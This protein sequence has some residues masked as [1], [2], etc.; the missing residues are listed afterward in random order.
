MVMRNG[1]VE[2]QKTVSGEG[3][4]VAARPAVVPSPAAANPEL[5]GRRPAT[6]HGRRLF[7]AREKLRVL[8]AIDRVAGQ[9]GEVGAILRREGLYSSTLSRW[10]KQREAG[11]LEA[12]TPAKRGPSPAVANPQTAELVQLRRDN[13]RLQQR[14]NRAEAIISVQKKVADLLGI[15]VD[16]PEPDDKP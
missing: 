4:A 7:S 11:M 5:S 13:A 8:A 1:A 10:R 2:A 14:L 6:A 9:A 15:A 3:G 16:R 12:L